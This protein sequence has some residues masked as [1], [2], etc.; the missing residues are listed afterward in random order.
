MNVK[1]NKPRQHPTAIQI[2][3]VIT[4]CGH[5]AG[6]DYTVMLNRQIPIP[7]AAVGHEELSVAKPQS[8]L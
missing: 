2:K 7:E 8:H 5:I 6:G 1:V 3:F 4:G